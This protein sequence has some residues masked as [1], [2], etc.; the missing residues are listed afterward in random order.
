MRAE[1]TGVFDRGMAVDI[2]PERGAVQFKSDCGSV[3]AQVP[4]DILSRLHD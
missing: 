2:V 3:V 4:L 1:F